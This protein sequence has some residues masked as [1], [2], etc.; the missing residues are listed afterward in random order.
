MYKM[1]ISAAFVCT[2]FF[3]GCHKPCQKNNYRFNGLGMFTP[4]KDSLQIGD[5]IWYNS[6]VPNQLM[7]N[8]LNQLIDYSGAT[9]F[10]SQI[11]FGLVSFTNPTGGAVDSFVFI[12]IKGTISTNPLLPNAA[13]TVAYIEQNGKYELSFGF[14][15]QKKGI[16]FVSVIDIGNSKKDCSDAIISL[17]LSNI[18]KHQYYL[19][20]IYFPGSPW[21]DSIPPIVQTHSYCFKVY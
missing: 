19:N 18:N 7:D 5:T 16:Y 21:G 11:N 4:E 14:V 9:N 1:L 13:K 8:N 10:R 12:P 6:S 3:N 20:A 2:I 17:T 15:A